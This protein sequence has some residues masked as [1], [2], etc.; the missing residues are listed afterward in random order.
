MNF[1]NLVAAT[2]TLLFFLIIIILGKCITLR[3]KIS[4]TLTDAFRVR[5][6]SFP[7][8]GLGFL[9]FFTSSFKAPF[10]FFVFAS[11]LHWEDRQPKPLDDHVQ[12]D[13]NC[14]SKQRLCWK[15]TKQESKSTVPET[16]YPHLHAAP[17]FYSKWVLLRSLHEGNPLPLMPWDTR[18]KY[19]VKTVLVIIQKSPKVF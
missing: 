2:S 14:S 18:F 12:E 17:L 13:G 16:S 10:L 5:V 3:C 1:F 4:T 6:P 7:L 11:S 9:I 15:T 8:P 19:L